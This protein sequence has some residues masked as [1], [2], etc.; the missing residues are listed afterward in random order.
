MT[1]VPLILISSSQTHGASSLTSGLGAAFLAAAVE[2]PK[3]RGGH[4]SRFGH[5][6]GLLLGRGA[7]SRPRLQ[8]AGAAF[9]QARGG[10]G[11]RPWV[12]FFLSAPGF[13]ATGAHVESPMPCGYPAQHM[14]L[15][16]PPGHWSSQID[17]HGRAK[18]VSANPNPYVLFFCCQSDCIVDGLS[19]IS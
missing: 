10:R 4:D 15:R 18:V 3:V 7:T 17:Q 19:R 6:E 1:I 8:G 2:A 14:T 13:V 16:T 11:A 9:V 12:I 5:R